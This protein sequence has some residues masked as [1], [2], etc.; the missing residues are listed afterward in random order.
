VVLYFS[1]VVYR[2][3]SIVFF[4]GANIYLVQLSSSANVLGYS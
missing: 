4:L 1:Y 2:N 3:S